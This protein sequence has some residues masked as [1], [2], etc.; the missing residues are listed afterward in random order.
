MNREVFHEQV[1]R[2]QTRWKNAFDEEFVAL[3]GAKMYAVS[4]ETFV[5]VV[6]QFIGD[7]PVSKPPLLQDFMQATGAASRSSTKKVYHLGDIRPKAL[8]ECMDCGDSGFVRLRRRASHDEW[9]RFEVGSAPCHCKQG[10]QVSLNQ[11]YNLGP[12][13]NR[14][15]EK[16]Y[17]I[18]SEYGR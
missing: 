13:F 15:W 7:R 8:A 9:A 10:K 18:I 11:K 2:L 14:L 16:S 1:K 17:E 5:D 4:N 12:Q 6:N 3:L